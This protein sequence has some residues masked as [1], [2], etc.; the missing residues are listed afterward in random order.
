MAIEVVQ[1][2]IHLPSERD[3]EPFLGDLLG[4]KV[5]VR[6][7]GK[8]AQGPKDKFVG[9]AYRAESGALAG[10]AAVDLPLAVALGASIAAL[11]PGTVAPIVTTGRFTEAV[12][13]NLYEVLNVTSRWFQPQQGTMVA[14]D[15]MWQGAEL[16]ADIRSALAA[17]PKK[18]E[19]KVEVQGYGG[20]M[21]LLAA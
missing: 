18:F 4:R 7:G 12:W 21:L 16:P 10:V 11:P 8:L 6:A 14:I 19:A 15:K 3:I 13:E 5:T 17:F 20:G 2:K 9:A 1:L